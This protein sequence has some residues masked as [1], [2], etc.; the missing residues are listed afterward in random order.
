M[1]YVPSEGTANNPIVVKAK[2]TAEGDTSDP[3]TKRVKHQPTWNDIF[4]PIVNSVPSED[5]PILEVRRW[6]RKIGSIHGIERHFLKDLRHMHLFGHNLRRA[7]KTEL[8]EY[9]ISISD[10][11]G[12][13]R[14]KCFFFHPHLSYL[15][16]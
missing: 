11:G 16:N 6:F 14:S 1:N 12:F 15:Y 9:L 2:R 3:S 7:D 5:A 13:L 4:Q 8:K 10:E